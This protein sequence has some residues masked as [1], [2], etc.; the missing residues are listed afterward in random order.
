MKYAMY[1]STLQI[2]YG[3]DPF[4]MAVEFFLTAS[5]FPNCDGPNAF[6][7]PRS[8]RPLAQTSKG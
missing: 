4:K 8:N 6:S 7:S 5:N 1:S 2:S 3:F